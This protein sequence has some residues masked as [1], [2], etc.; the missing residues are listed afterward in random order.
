[1]RESSGTAGA[2]PR[3]TSGTYPV[4]SILPPYTV[5]GGNSSTNSGSDETSMVTASAMRFTPPQALMRRRTPL[6]QA[7]G[8]PKLALMRR[9]LLVQPTSRSQ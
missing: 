3:N 6:V 4:I 2:V 9:T 1:M 7:Q 5:V 8:T